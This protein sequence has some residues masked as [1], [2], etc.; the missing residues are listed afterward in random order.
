ML[1]IHILINDTYE[2]LKSINLQKL[3]ND[4]IMILSIFTYILHYC[5]MLRTFPCLCH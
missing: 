3:N 4:P 5:G 2:V 1:L